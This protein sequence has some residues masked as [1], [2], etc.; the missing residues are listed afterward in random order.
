MSRQ[1][2]VFTFQA[3]WRNVVHPSSPG[4]YYAPMEGADR[5]MLYAVLLLLALVLF[6]IVVAFVFS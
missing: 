3:G 6:G 2:S 1:R 4:T 5:F